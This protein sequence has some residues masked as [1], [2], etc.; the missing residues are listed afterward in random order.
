MNAWRRVRR[1]W[2]LV[3]LVVLLQLTLAAFFSSGVRAAVGR[4]IEPYAVL[5]DGH[6]LG[7]LAALHRDNP[8]LVAGYQQV[9]LG[10]LLIS[11]LTW[12]LLS[13]IAITRLAA[14]PIA[15]SA[16]LRHVPAVLAT[17]LW[18]LLPR[19]VLLAAF[20]ALTKRL[21]P[22]DILGLAGIAATAI[23][24]AFCTCALDLARCH[25]VLHG[26]RRFH[27]STAFRAFGEAFHRPGVTLPSVLLSLAQWACAVG[28][29]AIA[30]DAAGA[31]S[32]LWLVRALAVVGVLC[33]LTRLAVAVEAGPA[34]S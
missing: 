4:S 2:R 13:P 28:M 25:V 32:T 20:G 21:M 19:A 17:S 33:G 3:L 18:H 14:S 9:M 22:H 12:I 34:R 27:P 6:L 29:L 24:L 23:A 11:A 7:A 15:A 16:S 26:A 8:G 1:A 30:I 5:A 10:S 31:P